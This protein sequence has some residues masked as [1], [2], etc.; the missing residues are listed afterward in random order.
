MKAHANTAQESLDLLVAM[1]VLR[2][3]KKTHA[4]TAP[5]SLD[6]VEAI[7]VRQIAT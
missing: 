5:E 7:G 1:Q 6:L 4:N 2:S 3:H